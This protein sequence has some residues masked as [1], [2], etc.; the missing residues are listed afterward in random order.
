MEILTDQKR[1]LSTGMK[2]NSERKTN[3]KLLNSR[4][5]NPTTQTI[6]SYF[7]DSHMPDIRPDVNHNNSK[8]KAREPKLRVLS[9]DFFRFSSPERWLSNLFFLSP[10]T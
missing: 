5:Q 1:S 2:G 4:Y 3:Q 6:M 7:K 10:T 9:Q 8:F